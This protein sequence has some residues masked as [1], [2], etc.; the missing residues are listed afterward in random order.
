MKK[1][2][3]LEVI[4]TKHVLSQNQQVYH[5]NR[6]RQLLKI[7]GII[8]MCLDHR[9]LFVEYTED[10][11]NVITIRDLL[12]DIGFPMKEQLIEPNNNVVFA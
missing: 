11:L 12:S 10:T 7:E 6:L 3:N 2:N 8:S 9:S 1:S 5:R 4:N